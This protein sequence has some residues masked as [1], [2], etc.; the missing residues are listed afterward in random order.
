MDFLTKTRSL[1]G[2]A[3]GAV[4]C[5]FAFYFLQRALGASI[6]DILPHYN[7]DIVNA[8]ISVYGEHGRWL[9]AFCAL[10]LD[11]LFPLCYAGFSAG[12]VLRLLKSGRFYCSIPIA[13]ATVD[14][15]E[16]IQIF[17]ILS[18]YPD[19]TE[20]QVAASSYTT[21]VKHVLIRMTLLLTL[22]VMVFGVI[23]K[24]F[25]TKQ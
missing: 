10:T 16:N 7:L 22:A 11:T 23:K 21:E 8:R 12:L 9:Y 19:I 17:I 5:A 3:V 4:G 18:G 2:L 14:W 13:L 6:L 20:I 25:I 1:V 24:L 15:A